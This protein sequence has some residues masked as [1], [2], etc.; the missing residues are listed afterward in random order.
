MLSLIYFFNQGKDSSASNDKTAM[1]VACALYL[2]TSF[3]YGCVIGLMPI[4]CDAV[5]G[6]SVHSHMTLLYQEQ[7]MFIQRI[8]MAIRLYERYVF[9]AGTL[10]AISLASTL[11]FFLS[12][13]DSL[14]WSYSGLLIGLAYLIAAASSFNRFHPD[15]MTAGRYG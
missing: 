5:F 6:P 12:A 1:Q 15:I 9:R 13:D 4:L 8:Q 7:N 2:V 11:I 14:L 10:I 3:V